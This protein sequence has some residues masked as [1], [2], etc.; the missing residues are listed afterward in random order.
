MGTHSGTHIDPPAHF[1]D[2]TATV[3]RIELSLL[4]GPAFVA[5]INAVERIGREHLEAA[6]IPPGVRRL[7][8]KTSNSSKGLMS[9]PDFDANFVSLSPAG[10]RW[11]VDHGVQIVGVDYLSVEAHS[12]LNHDTHR[13]LLGNRLSVLEGLDLG[14]IDPG[15]Y[16][17]FALPLKIARGDGAPV[18][19]VLVENI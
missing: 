12:D 1:F 17:L 5:E 3:D 8:L 14:N 10:A 15:H 18:R 16:L 2:G 19:A 11:I 6:K 13:V 4:C 7:I 9:R